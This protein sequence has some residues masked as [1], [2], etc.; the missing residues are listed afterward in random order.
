MKE[1]EEYQRDFT[2]ASRIYLALEEEIREL[3]K[4]GSS[5]VSLDETLKSFDL[6]VQILLLNLSVLDDK[7]TKE[8]LKF[9]HKISIE[10]D[11]IDYIN[12][13][14]KKNITWEDLS[15]STWSYE[16]F[17]DFLDYIS[18]I[19]SIKINSFILVVASKDAITKK[20]YAYKFYQGLKEL[21]CIFVDA[22][23][24]RNHE[25]EIDQILQKN[26]IVKYKALKSIFSIK[27]E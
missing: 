24:D 25:R 27:S 18:N 5:N 22:N 21:A 1:K 12:L 17:S 19:V 23:N 8:E 14:T 9:V 10:E 20:N 15:L 6:L 16:S 13:Q 4:F 7:I 2:Q 3:F 11:I 26:F